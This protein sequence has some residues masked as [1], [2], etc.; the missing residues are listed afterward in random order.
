MTHPTTADVVS[1]KRRAA[2]MTQQ[3]LADK[4]GVCRRTVCNWE[5]GSRIKPRDRAILDKIFA[6]TKGSK[7]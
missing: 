3:V 1:E 2:G 4:A 6:T 5:A 7:K